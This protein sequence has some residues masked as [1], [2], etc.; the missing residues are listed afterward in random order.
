MTTVAYKIDGYISTVSNTEGELSK[1]LFVEMFNFLTGSDCTSLGVQLIASGNGFTKTAQ[2]DLTTIPPGNPTATPQDRGCLDPRDP[3]YWGWFQY[4]QTDVGDLSSPGAWAVFRFTQADVPFDVFIQHFTGSRNRDTPSSTVYSVSAFADDHNY[5]QPNAV[6]QQS[7]SGTLYN[8]TLIDTVSCG[9][10]PYTRYSW[11]I[12]PLPESD[13]SIGNWKTQKRT[14]FMYLGSKSLNDERYKGG[15]VGVQIAQR[16][17]G[18]DPWA[19]ESGDLTHLFT[20]SKIDELTHVKSGLSYITS[21]DSGSYVLSGANTMWN[22][23]S[24]T[25]AVF[26]ISNSISGGYHTGSQKNLFPIIHDRGQAG[27]WSVRYHAFATKNDF[28]IFTSDTTTNTS[29]R[30]LYFGKYETVKS[31]HTNY[32]IDH[33]IPYVFLASQDHATEPAIPI[34]RSY[35]DGTDVVYPVT[36]GTK[37]GEGSCE[38]GAWHYTS[39]IGVVPVM[40]EVPLRSRLPQ[41]NPNRLYDTPKYDMHSIGVWINTYDMLLKREGLSYVGKLNN[42]M[43]LVAGLAS[44]DMTSDLSYAVLG[45]SS[46]TNWVAPVVYLSN[47]ISTNSVTYARQKIIVPWNS[48]TTIGTTMTKYGVEGTFVI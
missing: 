4:Q 32:P 19:Y 7:F 25:L 28:L 8:L 1:N 38:G 9:G 21:I 3:L 23:G 18:A 46:N 29:Y 37:H 40:L 13:Y 35:I 17:D 44:H 14:G 47:G 24:S 16:A 36:W 20:P 41:L 6:A 48:A 2:Y 45:N 31:N 33:P 22:S 42:L 12:S 5:V 10:G 15:S 30:Y 26:P 27:N 34:A 11:D 43:N 39:S